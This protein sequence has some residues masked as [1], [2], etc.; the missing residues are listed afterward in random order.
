MQRELEQ[1]V[2]QQDKQKRLLQRYLNELQSCERVVSEK[3]RK[4]FAVLGL[5]VI[6]ELCKCKGHF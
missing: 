6:G 1:Y 5:V 3:V 2:E 4:F